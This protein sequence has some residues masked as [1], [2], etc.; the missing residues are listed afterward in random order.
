MTK[1]RQQDTIALARFIGI[2]GQDTGLRTD[3][4]TGLLLFYPR[5]LKGYVELLNRPIGN[6]LHNPL[7]T[8]D[9]VRDLSEDELV[10]AQCYDQ[11]PP[12]Q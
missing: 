1:T 10:M 5:T 4:E 11:F 7:L 6:H 12:Y 8:V 2:T 3:H 9:Q